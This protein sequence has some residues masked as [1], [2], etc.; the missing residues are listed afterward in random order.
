MTAGRHPWSMCTLRASW[1]RDSARWPSAL[2]EHSASQPEVGCGLGAL[3]RKGS[4]ARIAA[5]R[6]MSVV[7]ARGPPVGRS[8]TRVCQ[9]REAFLELGPSVLQVADQYERLAEAVR[10]PTRRGPWGR[11]RWGPVR[12]IMPGHP[13]EGWSDLRDQ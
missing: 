11:G 3:V 9:G 10:R 5:W 2:Q 12:A 7:S 4:A 6:A 8:S 1:V 13:G